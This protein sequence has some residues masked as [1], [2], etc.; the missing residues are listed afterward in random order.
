MIH[1]QCAFAKASDVDLAVKACCFNAGTEDLACVL[2]T[3][4]HFARWR[5]WC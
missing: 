1:L 2:G 5:C 4:W 3:N